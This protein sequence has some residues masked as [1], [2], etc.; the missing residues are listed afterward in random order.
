MW[1]V[2]IY[3]RLTAAALRK[4]PGQVGNDWGWHKSPKSARLLPGLCGLAYALL[5]VLLANG[6]FDHWNAE[7][8]HAAGQQAF[9]EGDLSEAA[10]A[11]NRALSANPWAAAIWLKRAELAG[12][13]GDDESAVRYS[14]IA[15]QL[16]PFTLRVEWPLAHFRVKAGAEDQAALGLATIAASLPSL[17]PAVLEAAWSAGLDV[18]TIANLTQP[19]DQKGFAAYLAFLVRREDWG[20]IVPAAEALSAGCSPFVS[21][22]ALWPTFD[23]LFEAD[24]GAVLKGLWGVEGQSQLLPAVPSN[25]TAASVVAAPPMPAGQSNGFGWIARPAAGV[26]ASN[27]RDSSG[28]GRLSV[29]FKHP[30][31]IHYRHATS[32]FGVKPGAAYAL[33][34]EVRTEQLRGSQGIRVMVSSPKRFIT[35]SRPFAKT[36]PWR[37]VTLRF[38]TEPGEEI[39]RVVIVRNRGQRL[40]NLITG[41]FFLRNLNLRQ[42]TPGRR[43]PTRLEKR[44]THVQTAAADSTS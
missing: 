5:A 23:R 4:K 6:S 17:R 27:L 21:A 14:E 1:L 33:H 11:W 32:D 38:V 8:H 3:H 43:I 39:I 29:E 26:T 13:A 34:A 19:C 9:H 31:N 25:L 30:Q 18:A 24:Q 12:A 41:R 22:Q 28:D 20:G 16:E 35:S 7:I 42:E 37:T 10:H 44:A 15:G 2:R 40:D 36:T